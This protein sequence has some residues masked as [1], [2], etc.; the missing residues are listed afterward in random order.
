MDLLPPEME[1]A[2]D[3]S[4]RIFFGACFLLDAATALSVWSV[5]VPSHEPPLGHVIVT[6]SAP[7]ELTVSE[8]PAK[9]AM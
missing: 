2:P 9:E 8:D 1:K 6:V 7:L 3:A 4:V 5:S